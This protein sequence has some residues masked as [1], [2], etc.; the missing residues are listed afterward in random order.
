MEIRTNSSIWVTNHLNGQ[1]YNKIMKREV[2]NLQTKTAIA[3]SLKKLMSTKPLN[4]ITVNDIITDCD[5]NRKTFYYHFED[6]HDL[7]RWILELEAF[8]VVKQF[9]IINNPEQAID[10]VIQ[11]V[12]ENEHILNCVY[13]SI[14]R[15]ELKRFFVNDFHSNIKKIIDD[16]EKAHQL[17]VSNEFKDFLCDFSTEAIAGVLVDAFTNKRIPNNE[18]IKHNIKIII[19]SLP[20]ILKRAEN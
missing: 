7:V 4:K 18:L 20:D 1:L 17:S 15:D 13:D 6:I 10:F 16:C 8:E 14:G 19:D 11:Y 5:V 3:N 12:T 9:D 2:A